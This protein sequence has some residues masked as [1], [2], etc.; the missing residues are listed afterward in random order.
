MLF[1]IKMERVS[2]DTKFERS[3]DFFT[4]FCSVLAIYKL[5]SL[6]PKIALF[7]LSIRKIIYFKETLLK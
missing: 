1:T 2:R 3:S 4:K 5:L 7:K 6:I